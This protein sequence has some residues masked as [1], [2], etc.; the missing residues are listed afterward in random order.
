VQG[1]LWIGVDLLA[2]EEAVCSIGLACFI[3][4]TIT[5]SVNSSR[6]TLL[7]TLKGYKY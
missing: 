3:S 1:I 7:L 5:A 6:S 4:C 2:S